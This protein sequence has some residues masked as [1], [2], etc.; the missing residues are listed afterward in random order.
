MLDIDIYDKENGVIYI[1]VFSVK[2][3]KILGSVRII[4]RQNLPI[5]KDCFNFKEPLSIKLFAKH[6]IAE[7]SRL[8]IMP[9][10]KN[11]FLPRHLILIIMIKEVLQILKDKKIFFVYAFIKSK[12]YFKFKKI[13][14]PFYSIKNYNM[15]YNDG[16]LKEYFNQ[17][18]DPVLPVY[19]NYFFVKLFLVLT[20]VKIKKYINVID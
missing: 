18:N 16:V 9:Y 12:L 8:I 20:Y 5:L 19:F 4:T 14:L 7:L 15:K 11:K 2:L 1:N 13:K 6:N 17:K 3:K 10:T